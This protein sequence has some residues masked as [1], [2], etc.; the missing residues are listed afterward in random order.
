[1]IRGNLLNL[2]LVG[3]GDLVGQNKPLLTNHKV[4]IGVFEVNLLALRA[5][6][7]AMVVKF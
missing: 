2:T 1:M 7:I 5:D 3:L 6:G 4:G